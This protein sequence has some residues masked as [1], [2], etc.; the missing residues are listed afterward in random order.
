MTSVI[1]GLL[2][3]CFL[4]GGFALHLTIPP[5]STPM[6]SILYADCYPLGLVVMILFSLVPASIVFDHHNVLVRV[7]FRLVYSPISF[8]V[9]LHTSERKLNIPVTA[10][11]LCSGLISTSLQDQQLAMNLF[12]DPHPSLQNFAAGLIRECLSSDPLIASQSQFTYSIEVLGQLAQAGDA[13]E[14]VNRLLDDLR[15]VRRPT[16]E[17]MVVCQPS[18]KPETEQ[19]R[20]KLF[21]WFQQWGSIFQRSHSPEKAFVPFISQLTKQEILKV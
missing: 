1:L 2:H 16:M 10:T 11:L 9:P 8:A 15:V 18:V 4:Y 13:N 5:T 21:N 19:L 3:V 14:E 7:S 17:G 20:E 12:T 6:T